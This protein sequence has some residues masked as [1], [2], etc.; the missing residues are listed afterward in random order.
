MIKAA[1]WAMLT[2]SENAG[3]GSFSDKMALQLPALQAAVE[4]G[5][6]QPLCLAYDCPAAD[7]L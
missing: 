2:P 7:A 6:L 1:S 5:S 4:L 3:L